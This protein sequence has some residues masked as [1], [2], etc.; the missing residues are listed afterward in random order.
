MRN[1]QNTQ[2]F[3]DAAPV[4]VVG[5]QM[6]HAGQLNVEQIAVDVLTRK[7]PCKPSFIACVVLRICIGALV[8]TGMV[9]F[10][11]VPRVESAED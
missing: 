7:I 9:V 6:C 4:E 3:R 5:S 2:S 11:S 10:I 1:E 8:C